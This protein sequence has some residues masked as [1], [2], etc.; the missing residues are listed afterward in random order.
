MVERR[1]PKPEV[2]GSSPSSPAIGKKNMNKLINYFKKIRLELKKVVWL[3]KSQLI[4]STFV[5][6]IFAII[7]GLFLFVADVIIGDVMDRLYNL[8]SKK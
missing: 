7:V 4:N 8:I 1:P 2:E 5:V 6:F 3:N